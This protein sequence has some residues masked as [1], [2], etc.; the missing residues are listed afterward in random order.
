MCICWVSSELMTLRPSFEEVLEF[1]LDNQE[2]LGVPE[3]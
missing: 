3:I 1:W 2:S